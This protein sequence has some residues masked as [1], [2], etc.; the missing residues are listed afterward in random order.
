MANLNLEV[1]QANFTET[2]TT[3]SGKT[4]ISANIIAQARSKQGGKISF[5]RIEKDSES[6]PTQ[7]RAEVTPTPEEAEKIAECFAI[8]A[9][10]AQ[11]TQF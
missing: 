4:V 5:M 2:D 10:Y 3:T 7:L 8:I 6:E 11:D 1:F 9:Y